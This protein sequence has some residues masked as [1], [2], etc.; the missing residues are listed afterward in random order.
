MSFRQFS[1]P[2][3]K[4]GDNVVWV[5]NSSWHAHQHKIIFNIKT[6]YCRDKPMTDIETLAY[7]LYVLTG[8]KLY[9]QKQGVWH[10]SEKKSVVTV[11]YYYDNTVGH[12]FPTVLGH[13]VEKYVKNQQ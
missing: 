13:D 5:D 4:V 6:I 2:I 7:D 3:V 12:G 1:T 8:E 9:E 11:S 10:H